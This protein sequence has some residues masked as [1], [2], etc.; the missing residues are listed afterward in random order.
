[1]QLTIA[2]LTLVASKAASAAAVDTTLARHPLHPGDYPDGVI[3][4]AI[5]PDDIPVELRNGTIPDDTKSARDLVKRDPGVYLCA[6]AN[7][8]GY[9][10][11]ISTPAYVCGKTVQH[12]YASSEIWKLN[13]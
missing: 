1:M 6:E 8:Q 3:V 10:V 7:W 13:Y 9:C 11:H 5:D 2:L 12:S 4:T